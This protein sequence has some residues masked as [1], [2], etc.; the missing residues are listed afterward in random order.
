MALQKSRIDGCITFINHFSLQQGIEHLV[1]YKE[2]TGVGVDG[3]LLRAILG[4]QLS[5]NSADVYLPNILSDTPLLV[6]LVGGNK[7]TS[8]LNSEAFTSRFPLST[9]VGYVSGDKDGLKAAWESIKNSNPD[10]VVLGLGPGLQD[11][12]AL[13]LWKLSRGEGNV[14]LFVTCGGWLDQLSNPD[15]FPKW[16]YKLRLNWL[17]RLVREPRRLWKRYSYWAFRAIAKRSKLRKSVSEVNW[18][19]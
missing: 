5:H 16:S 4:R 2:F 17:L 10:L 6:F 19:G 8:K 15:F 3:F 1:N 13:R 11:V 14:R 7:I 9:V 18:L 12:E